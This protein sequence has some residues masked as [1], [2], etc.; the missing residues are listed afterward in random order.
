MIVTVLCCACPLFGQDAAGRWQPE[1]EW[2]EARFLRPDRDLLA[3]ARELERRG[4]HKAA[5]EAYERLGRRS[6]K[7]VNQALALDR[8]AAN[9]LRAGQYREARLAYEKL[10]R[11]YAG[12]V[13]LNDSLANLRD[14]AEHYA[15]RAAFFRGDGREDAIEIYQLILE[16]APAGADSRIN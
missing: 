15:G 6:R 2:R 4:E 8:E 3:R 9:R 13:S 7:T 11:Q 10:V 16:S 5:A 14:L 1:P 12:Q